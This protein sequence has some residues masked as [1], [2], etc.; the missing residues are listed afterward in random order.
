MSRK[1]VR[2]DFGLY[3][4]LTTIA[5]CLTP[6]AFT[7]STS[8]EQL[9]NFT[10]PYTVPFSNYISVAQLPAGKSLTLAT[11]SVRISGHSLLS[12]NGSVSRAFVQDVSELPTFSNS[13]AYFVDILK[14]T[15]AEPA[16]AYHTTATG[17]HLKFMQLLLAR[18]IGQI[19]TRS[20]LV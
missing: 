14:A 18:P 10:S 2:V 5:F 15:P 6:L 17:R 4:S 3:L 11:M 20:H 7:A 1:L 13:S 9:I 12:Q 19:L 8:N 16:P